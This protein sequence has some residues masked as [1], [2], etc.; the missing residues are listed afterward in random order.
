MPLCKKYI[1]DTYIN[2]LIHYKYV[3]NNYSI[4]YNYFISPICNVIVQ[5][6]PKW[7]LPNTITAIGWLLNV[8][9][10]VL[11]TI[12]GGW[13]GTDY[14]PSWLCYLVSINYSLY[15]YLD[16]IDG[17]HAR[18]INASSPLGVLF[19]H[20]SDACTSFFISVIAGSLVYY[21]NINQYL[22]IYIPL[23]FTFFLNF[24]EE[25]YT[26]VLDLPIIN[27]VE[28]G[29]I[30]ASSL[31]F[32]SGLFGA[33][34]FNTKYNF[35][36]KYDLK[37][38]EIIGIVVLIGASSH[39]IKSFYDI[40]KK[41]KNC[42][43]IDIFKSTSIYILHIVSLLTV[44]F[45]N[46]SIIVTKYPKVLLL[47]Y[48]F[49]I[50]TISGTIQL[51]KIIKCPL[52]LYRPKFL[53]PLLIIILHSIIRYL[54]NFTLF[55]SIDLLII[56]AFIWDFMFWLHYV[57]FCSEEICE[58]LNINRFIPGKRYPSRPSYYERNG[59]ENV[60]IN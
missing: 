5:Y 31:F 55:I 7:L 47:A 43:T 44:V 11:T 14:L 29:S 6:L 25:Y 1:E 36:N 24:I 46:D 45:L 40:K 28:E 34:L 15:I 42:K 53:I 39:C 33:E 18:R 2:N 4:Y 35:F 37:I 51:S 38:S 12:Y 17:K 10:L 20:G 54:F 48:G 19:D 23:T 59:L 56:L 3:G 60:E 22:F 58:I 9:S 16:S 27:G 8:L 52:Y 50:A 21:D 49:Q 41:A 13:K 30:V 26:G 57:Y 32:I